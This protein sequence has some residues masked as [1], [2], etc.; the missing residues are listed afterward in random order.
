M[1][2]CLTI[3]KFALKA[4][5]LAVQYHFEYLVLMYTKIK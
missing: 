4:G 1:N 5:I 3:E 2:D